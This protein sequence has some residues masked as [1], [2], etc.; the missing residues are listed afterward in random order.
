[1]ENCLVTKLMSVVKN[2]N[3]DYLDFLRINVKSETTPDA[4]DF[5]INVTTS[6]AAKLYIEG[7]GHFTDGT[8]TEDRGKEANTGTNLKFSNGN[9]VL[10]IPLMGITSLGVGSAQMINITKWQNR[11]L[12]YERLCKVNKDTLVEIT[13]DDVN[14]LLACSKNMTNVTYFHLICYSVVRLEPML[15]AIVEADGRTANFSF[16]GNYLKDIYTP[17]SGSF[18]RN[19]HVTSNTQYSVYNQADTELLYTAQKVNGVWTHTLAQ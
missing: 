1:M 4:D 3:L 11:G 16:E 18:V 17:A 2:D 10:K 14:T 9:Y 15:D 7:D 5:S 6:P 8:L 13:F 19:I 12:D